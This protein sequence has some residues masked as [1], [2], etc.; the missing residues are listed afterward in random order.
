MAKK[1]VVG[2][3]IGGTNIRSALVNLDGKI[4]SK[5]KNATGKDPL[6]VLHKQL[7]SVYAP[8]AKEVIGIGIAVAGLVDRGTGTVIRSPNIPKLNGVSLSS[9]VKKKYKACVAVENDANAAACG[10]KCAGA[11]KDFKDFVMITLGTGIGG[12]VVLNNR[13]LPIAAEIGHM[14]INVEGPQCPCGNVGCLEL[15]AS[16]TAIVGN[17]VAEIEKGKGSILKDAYNG[18]F[19]K[20]TAEDIYKAALEGDP[21]ARNVLREAGKGLGVGIASLIN[22]FGPEAIILTGGLIGAWNIFIDSAIKEASKRAM[23]ELYNR[24]Q[25]IPSSLGDDAGIAGAAGLI[26]EQCRT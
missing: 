25:I 7:D 24:V 15:Y 4:V 18:N 5:A 12:G 26:F 1:Y 20:I 3:D 10:E 23:K 22:I 8:Y 14:S 21:L 13:L 19:Y 6:S 11:G 16:A 2:V 17:A 9:E